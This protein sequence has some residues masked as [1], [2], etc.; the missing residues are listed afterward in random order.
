MA[1]T[2]G[3]TLLVVLLQIGHH[4]TAHTVLM[5]TIGATVSFGVSLLLKW[6]TKKFSH[7][8]TIISKHKKQQQDG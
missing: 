5:A 3:G 8:Q 2:A 1:G 7:K 6:L 4:E